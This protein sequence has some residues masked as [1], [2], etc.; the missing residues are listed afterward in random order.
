MKF[1][2]LVLCLFSLERTFVEAKAKMDKTHSYVTEE[3]AE[4]EYHKAPQPK[5][6]YVE[7]IVEPKVVYVEK[8]EKHYAPPPQKNYAPPPQKNY[9]PPQK[10]YAPPPQKNYA[11]PPQK[12]YAPPQQKHY[13]PPPQKNF[14]AQ[15]NI[16]PR[17]KHYAPE[18]LYRSSKV[19]KEQRVEYVPVAVFDKAPKV[20]YSMSYEPVKHSK[21]SAVKY[22]P[23]N[24][25]K[26]C[27]L[28]MRV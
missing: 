18:P 24:C 2:L 9:A 17:Q 12:H 22:I 16:V 19:Y 7:K 6:V 25:G 11:P 23:V 4:P 21:G 15:T 3:W 1:F 20:S 10:N 13:A 14:V 26:M 8:K 28:R 27:R 5:V